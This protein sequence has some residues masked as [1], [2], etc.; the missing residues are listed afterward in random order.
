MFGAVPSK[1]YRMDLVFEEVFKF[2]YKTPSFISDFPKI[3]CK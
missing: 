2:M 1:V 3:S